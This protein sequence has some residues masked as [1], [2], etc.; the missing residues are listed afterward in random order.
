MFKAHVHLLVN[1][2]W[3]GGGGSE[4]G[5]AGLCLLIELPFGCLSH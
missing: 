2:G 1:K 5:A 4:K 3:E